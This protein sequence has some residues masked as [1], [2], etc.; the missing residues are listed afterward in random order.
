MK[1]LLVVLAIACVA[2]SCS[3]K[4]YREI[5]LPSTYYND[6]TISLQ[7]EIPFF[8]NVSDGLF[9]LIRLYDSVHPD[10]KVQAAVQSD[11]QMQDELKKDFSTGEF[12]DIFAA[13]PSAFIDKLIRDDRLMELGSVFLENRDW[14]AGFLYKPLWIPVRYD[15]RTYGLPVLVDYGCMVINKEA[16]PSPQVYPQ[17]L[18][19][20]YE[21]A[22]RLVGKKYVLF[23]VETPGEMRQ[24]IAS[25]MVVYNRG[26]NRAS[27]TAD[28]KASF[29]KSVGFLRSLAKINALEIGS[30]IQ[31]SLYSPTDREEALALVQDVSDRYFQN[32]DRYD[33]A[34]YP[35]VVSGGDRYVVFSPGP[36]TIYVSRDP[37]RSTAETEY[38]LDFLEF[39]TWKGSIIYHNN[40]EYLINIKTDPL[41]SDKLFG[42]PEI[43]RQYS[44]LLKEG[45]SDVERLFLEDFRITASERNGGDFQFN[46]GLIRMLEDTEMMSLPPEYFF[47]AMLDPGFGLG[48]AELVLNTNDPGG[49]WDSM[50]SFHGAADDK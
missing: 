45:E 18:D 16:F 1:K 12:P 29:I 8:S 17:S 13:R 26:I 11:L 3:G 37:L 4:R 22:L 34:P 19:D 6:D 39:I 42:S 20:L 40:S 27:S 5:D 28:L 7:V 44:A 10:I 48:A 15:G 43:A 49:W 21:I 14:Y 50:F 24:L 23:R 31:N 25:L 36:L 41:D 32:G 47:S 30:L 2:V 38:I 46:P 9:G 33:Y 35:A